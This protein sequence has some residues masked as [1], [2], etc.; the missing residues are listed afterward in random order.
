MNIGPLRKEHV[1]QVAAM[2]ADQLTGFLRALGRPAAQAFYS[3]CVQSPR[4][5]GIVAL[6]GADVKGF[7]CGSMTP[8][9][10]KIDA[11]AR[12]LGPFILGAALGLL[13][14]PKAIPFVMDVARGSRGTGL[15]DAPELTYLA[16]AP[17]ARRSGIGRQ[18]VNAFS[19]A[20]RSAG[21]AS[22]ELSVEHD[23]VGA[24]R[25]YRELG[26]EHVRNYREFGV[27]HRR[28]RLDLAKP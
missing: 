6:D 18:L 27:D 19:N 1:R 17:D 8:R 22:Y 4:M 16:V 28:Y 23:N 21:A 10:L 11:L 20:I 24:D 9:S 13:R 7:V 26:F 15:P 25:F 5:I 2:H 3:G 12:N 14:R